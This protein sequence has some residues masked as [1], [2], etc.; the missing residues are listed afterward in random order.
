MDYHPI[1]HAPG[2]LRSA[3]TPAEIVAVCERAFGRGVG[4]ISARTARGRVQHNLP[5]ADGQ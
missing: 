4:V 2:D 1:Q 3:L 5:G